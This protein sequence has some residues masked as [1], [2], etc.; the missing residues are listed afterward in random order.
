ML[1]LV[2]IGWTEI[3]IRE[4][5]RSGRCQWFR[6]GR[7]GTPLLHGH[8]LGDR[9]GLHNSG[10]S[11]AFHHAEKEHYY[12]YAVRD[13]CNYNYGKLTSEWL[14]ADNVFLHSSFSHLRHGRC[15]SFPMEATRSA[16]TNNYYKI[17][18]LNS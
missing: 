15:H 16:E 13:Y 10:Y 18:W 12:R 6:W 4:I 1:T 2:F 11:R 7:H 9:K 3:R 14:P 8:N 17:R 5:K